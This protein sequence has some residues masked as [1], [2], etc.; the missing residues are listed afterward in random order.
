MPDQFDMFGDGPPPKQKAF[1]GKTYD[2]SRDY[3][4]L[5][6]QL[7]RTWKVMSD[8]RERTLEGIAKE[9]SALRPDSGRDL[10]TAIS[11]RIR[12]FRKGQFGAHKVV[13]RNAGGGLWWY[14][15][16]TPENDP[17]F[18]L[19]PMP[20]QPLPAPVPA[21]TNAYYDQQGRLIHDKCAESG[22]TEKGSHSVGLA[23]LKGRLGMWYCVKHWPGDPAL[24]P[25]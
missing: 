1:G 16:V 7:N 2:V 22:C 4:R 17:T 23:Q 9:T 15:L 6:S 18:L 12:D 19:A 20:D 5:K 24:K 13:S 8:G 10:P 14:R 3:A 25:K 11:A 21:P